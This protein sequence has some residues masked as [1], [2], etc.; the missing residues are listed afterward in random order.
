MSRRLSSVEVFPSTWNTIR[1]YWVQLADL[2]K[3]QA[4]LESQLEGDSVAEHHKRRAALQIYREM[5][6]A[7]WSHNGE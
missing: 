5:L 1:D 7:M 3:E 2:D 4:R 6:D